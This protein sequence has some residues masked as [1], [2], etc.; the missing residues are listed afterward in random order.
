MRV[1]AQP[2]SG[3]SFF[4]LRFLPR[5]LVPKLCLG[6]E[7]AGSG[8]RW[9]KPKGERSGER[10][11]MPLS[12]QLCCPSANETEFRRQVRSQ[13]EFGNE[14]ILSRPTRSNPHWRCASVSPNGREKSLC[15]KVRKEFLLP[16]GEG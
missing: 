15:P 16:E 7:P 11:S 12:W 5:S 8:A 14:D 3:S 2:Q 4:E 6:I 9:T 10:E 1:L 13:T